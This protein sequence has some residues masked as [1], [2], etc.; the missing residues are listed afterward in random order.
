MKLG[1]MYFLWMLVICFWEDHGNM[2]EEL[3]MMGIGTHTPLSKMESRL[4][5]DP[6]NWKLTKP[7]KVSESSLLI[8]FECEK[9]LKRGNKLYVLVV[10]E[11]NEENIELPYRVKCLLKEFPNVIQE[12]ILHGLPSMRDIQ[13]HI[14]LTPGSI[15]LNK[16]I[17]RISI[18]KH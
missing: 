1:V 12:D 14:N 9:E 17:Y 4:F 16:A 3:C 11:E 2:I 15:L 18:K 5:Q 6:L 7:S 8:K 13:H 10:L